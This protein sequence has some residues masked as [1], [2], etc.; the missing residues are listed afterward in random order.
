MTSKLEILEGNVAKIDMTIDAKEAENAY[1]KAFR[2]ISQNVNIAGFRK[3]KAPK[4]IVEKYVGAERIKAEAIEDIFPKEFSKVSEEHKLDLAMQ[5]YIES[6]DFEA[7][8]DMKLTVKAELKPE[9]KLAKYKEELKDQV[10]AK[11]AKLG[12]EGY[13]EY[14]KQM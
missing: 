10:A 9:V 5:P 3:G 13:G 14:L 2:K 6:Y 8:K 4:N 7:G 1:N 11:D 12:K